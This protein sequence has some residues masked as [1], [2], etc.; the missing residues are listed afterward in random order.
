MNKTVTCECGWTFTGPEEDLIAA[1]QRHGKD[2]H[3]MDLTREQALAQ[4]TPI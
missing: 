3:G 4:A 2:V 1:V